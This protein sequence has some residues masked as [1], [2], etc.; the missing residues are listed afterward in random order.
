MVDSGAS[1]V[2]LEDRRCMDAGTAAVI[3]DNS[4]IPG[5]HNF[6]VTLYRHERNMVVVVDL[7]NDQPH[8]A[9][10]L[11][12]LTVKSEGLVIAGRTVEHALAAVPM[13]E[14]P[15]QPPP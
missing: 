6:K 10:P 11:T 13:M 8:A 7:E 5:K 12:A 9:H 15:R 14:F 2:R 4:R 3:D 1:R